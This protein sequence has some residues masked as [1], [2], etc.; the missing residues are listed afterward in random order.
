MRTICPH[1]GQAGRMSEESIGKTVRCPGCGERF[2]IEEEFAPELTPEGTRLCPYCSELIKAA[3]K[4]C[5]HCGETVDVTLRTAEEARRSSDRAPNVYMNAGGGG[6]AAASSSAGGDRPWWAWFIT[7]PGIMLMFG[8]LGFIGCA[9]FCLFSMVLS[10][11][12]RPHP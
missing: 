5:R 3:A 11:G 2:K 9:G 1:C 7:I 8:G 6:A 4:K 12:A 10:A